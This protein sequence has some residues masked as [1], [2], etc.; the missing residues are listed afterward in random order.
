MLFLH[1]VHDFPVFS[2]VFFVDKTNLNRSY[3]T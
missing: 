1:E 2:F 3:M